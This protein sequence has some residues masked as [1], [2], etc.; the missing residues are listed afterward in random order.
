M[1]TFP[2]ETGGYDMPKAI[3]FDGTMTMTTRDQLAGTHE[4]VINGMV[5]DS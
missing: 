2:P 5:L 1:V 3:T 4:N